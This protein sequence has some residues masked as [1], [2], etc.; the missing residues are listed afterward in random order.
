MRIQCLHYFVLQVFLHLSN[1]DRFFYFPF[2]IGYLF[3]YFSNFPSFHVSVLKMPS[4]YYKLVHTMIYKYDVLE[5]LILQIIIVIEQ[6]VTFL[7]SFF[8]I[9]YLFMLYYVVFHF[10]GLF[11]SYA[12][13]IFL[14]F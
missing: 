8:C 5:S 12:F 14:F 3:Y 7:F 4:A 6:K 13:T 11:Q 1:H 2:F 9:V 10:F